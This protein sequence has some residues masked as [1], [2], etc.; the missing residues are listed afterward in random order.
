MAIRFRINWQKAL[1]A[2]VWLA[3]EKPGVTFY[4]VVKLLFFAD[5][6]HLQKYGRPVIGDRY[7]AMPHGPVP[8]IVY[9]MLK[10]DAFLAPDILDA[11]ASSL[12]INYT[13]HPSIKAKRKVNMDHFSETDLE[14]L[15]EALEQYGDMPFS[16][17]RKIT[18][19]EPAYIEADLNC[20]M[21]Y[22]LMI[23]EDTPDREEKISDLEDYSHYMVV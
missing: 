1:E 20:E 8:T 2:L 12:E 17:L 5:K 21:D 6:A 15:R 19:A 7:I 14:C 23:D 18:H 9:N 13:G 10:Q 3:N 22:A 16:R 11:T 4:Y